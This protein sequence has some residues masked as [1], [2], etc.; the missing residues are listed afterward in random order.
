[1]PAELIPDEF[2]VSLFTFVA[3]TLGL[4]AV[5]LMLFRA[6]FAAFLFCSVRDSIVSFVAVADAFVAY[7]SFYIR[8]KNENC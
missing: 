3:V 7:L 5:L 2:N 8:H 4:F 1:M 6:I